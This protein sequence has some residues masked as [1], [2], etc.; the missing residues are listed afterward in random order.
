MRVMVGTVLLFFGCAT[1]EPDVGAP[2]QPSGDSGRV[3]VDTAR[4]EQRP[5]RHLD[6]AGVG[7]W[8]DRHAIIG[9][10]IEQ[11]GRAFD[12]K[13]KPRFRVGRAMVAADQRALEAID[14]PA[15][16]LSAGS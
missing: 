7:S 1:A 10:K 11:L 5:K 4:P 14:R 2:P 13:R 12:R 15:G 16:M 3:V 9:G 8:H 6:R